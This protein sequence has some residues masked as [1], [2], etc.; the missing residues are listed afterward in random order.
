MGS[1]QDGQGKNDSVTA[2]FGRCRPRVVRIRGRGKGSE[3]IMN[4]TCN[5]AAPT[6]KYATRKAAGNSRA[7]LVT[8]QDSSG[9]LA[10]RNYISEQPK[11]GQKELELIYLA[12][13]SP[14]L[15]GRPTASRFLHILSY[16]VHPLCLQSR[17]QTPYLTGGTFTSCSQKSESKG[18]QC[19]RQEGNSGSR[20]QLRFQPAQ[21]A[22]KN[23]SQGS[24]GFTQ[25]VCNT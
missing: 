22:H 24:A 16:M 6:I 18:A 11:T 19:V 17:T 23:A 25:K 13:V 2:F 8:I 5:A 9:K 14:L 10:K 12:P 15:K 21:G 20:L 4:N 3:E 1:S 7:C